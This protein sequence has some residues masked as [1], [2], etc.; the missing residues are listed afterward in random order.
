LAPAFGE[1]GRAT[2]LAWA[3]R[4]VAALAAKLICRSLLAV[5]LAASTTLTKLRF[6]PH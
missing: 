5:V 4:L 3:K 6:C 2:F 1:S